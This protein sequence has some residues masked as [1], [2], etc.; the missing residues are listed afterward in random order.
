LKILVVS[1]FYPP[2]HIGGYELGCFNVVQQLKKRGHHIKVLTSTYGVSGQ[3][4][5]DEVLRRLHLR[6]PFEMSKIGKLFKLFCM[7]KNNQSVFSR[8][9]GEFDPDIVYFWNMGNISI[10]LISVAQRMKKAICYYVFD[11]WLANWQQNPWN[12]F[13]ANT[14]NNFMVALAK[15]LLCPIA[16]LLSLET[17]VKSPDLRYVQFASNYLKRNAIT[18]KMG[19]EGAEVIYWGIDQ[20]KFSYNAIKRVPRRILY[21]GQ[22]VRHKGLHTLIEAFGVLLRENPSDAIHLQVVG[23]S[24]Q[25][26]YERQMRQMVI[27]LNLSQRVSFLGPVAQEEL[28]GI[29]HQ[30]D[31]LVFPSIW[32]EPFGITLLEAMSCGLGI[33]STQTG[34]IPE[35]LTDEINALCFSKENAR[36][37]VR[38]ISRLLHDQELFE[39]IR[40]NARQ[41]VEKK[42]NLKQAIENIENSLLKTAKGS[43]Q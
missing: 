38:Q 14:E 21:V 17:S 32:E 30:N 2:Y 35:I 10:S 31:I 42:L 36:D 25:P 18:H 1:N 24:T 9:C 6:P 15:I 4:F 28:P 7:E 39:N 8:L 40:L 3:V 43:Q 23:G 26:E 16:R 13:W 19:A 29:Y 37:C 12:T 20:E 41:T 22:I 11:D 27:D 5:Q 34:G 33:V